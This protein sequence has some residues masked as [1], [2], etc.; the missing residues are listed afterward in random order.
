MR[1]LILP[2]L[3]S[4]GACSGFLI[5]MSPRDTTLVQSYVLQAQIDNLLWEAARLRRDAIASYCLPCLLIY[6]YL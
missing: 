2:Q 6:D 3:R 4:F 5:D 1:V